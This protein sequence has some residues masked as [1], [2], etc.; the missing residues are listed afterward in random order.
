MSEKVEKFLEFNG[1]TIVL[2]AKDGIWWI[3]IRP[4]CEALGVQYVRDY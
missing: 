1:K 4:V 2:L 3:A